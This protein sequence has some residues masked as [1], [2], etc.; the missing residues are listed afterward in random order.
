MNS[1]LASRPASL[2]SIPLLHF[3][4]GKFAVMAL[5]RTVDRCLIVVIR[6]HLVLASVKLALKKEEK[7]KN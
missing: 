1:V 4:R 2:G 5:L 7:T 6:T 3:F